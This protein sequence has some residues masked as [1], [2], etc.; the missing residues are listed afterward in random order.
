MRRQR[1]EVQKEQDEVRE[2][3]MAAELKAQRANIE[4]QF[5]RRSSKH[6]E[7]RM[8]DTPSKSQSL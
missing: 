5:G 4:P 7:S 6:I 3:Q 8:R 2:R 1:E